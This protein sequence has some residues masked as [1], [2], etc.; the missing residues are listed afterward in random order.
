MK[1]L[2]LIITSLVGIV[3]G[4]A[5]PKESKNLSCSVLYNV[6]NKDGSDVPGVYEDL[7][8]SKLDIKTAVGKTATSS[9]AYVKLQVM[10]QTDEN[11]KDL[12]TLNVWDTK[13]KVL[14]TKIKNTVL[15]NELNL[16]VRLPEETRGRM[17]KK[18]MGDIAWAELWCSISE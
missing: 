17:K 9:D 10:T 16:F 7:D 14:L 4:A 2:V 12:L 13:S 11:G 6:E 15:V 3:A 18:N 8:T 5:Q 1:I